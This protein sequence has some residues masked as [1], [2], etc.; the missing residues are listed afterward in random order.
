MHQLPQP[1]A[2]PARHADC[3]RRVLRTEA[4]GLTALA[5][6][7][8]EDFGA[9]VTALLEGR[10]RVILSGMGKSGHIARKIAATLASTG[11]PALFIHPAEASH[12]DLGM[13]TPADL[14]MVISNSGETAELGDLLD[15][16]LR[17]DVGIIGVSQAPDST[18]MRAARWRLLLPSE[19]EACS[20]GVA[21]TTSTTMAL[22][23]GDALAIA[24]ME[25]RAFRTEAFR[26]L[27]PGGRL[28]ARLATMRQLMHGGD[29]LPVVAPEAPMSE[30]ILTMTRCGFGITAVVATDGRLFGVITDGDLRRNMEGLLDRRAEEVA[31]RDPLTVAPETIAVQAL[32]AMNARKVQAVLVVEDGRPVG[33]VRLHDCLRAGAA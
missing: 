17:F 25:A 7:L 22:G 33:V 23:L 16:C 6:A 31:T 19:P 29:S 32:A 26:S 1:V 20:L 11:T 18:L 15:Y 10:G 14:A 5:E 4:H 30:A 13:I 8:P 12:G 2:S 28:G 24:V 21:P 27:H 3:A 9:A